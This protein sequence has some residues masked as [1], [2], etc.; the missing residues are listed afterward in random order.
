MNIAQ[1]SP[2]SPSGLKQ[3]SDSDDLNHPSPNTLKNHSPIAFS[4]IEP[5]TNGPQ[6]EVCFLDI[7]SCPS[8]RD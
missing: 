3:T 6:S 7:V 5:S 1:S 8:Y 2:D 4:L